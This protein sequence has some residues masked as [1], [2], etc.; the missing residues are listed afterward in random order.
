MGGGGDGIM[1]RK[2]REL[3]G[4]RSETEKYLENHDKSEICTA[5]FRHNHASDSKLL[6]YE[7]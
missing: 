4:L 6:F 3:K 5:V 1:R 7:K 2:T